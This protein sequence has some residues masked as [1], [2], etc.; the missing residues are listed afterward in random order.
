MKKKKLLLKLAALTACSVIAFTGCQVK[1]DNSGSSSANTES[2]TKKGTRKIV[3]A[4]GRTVEIPEKV[5]KV[6]VDSPT[7]FRLYSYINKS[8][9][10]VGVSDRDKNGAKDVPYGFAFPEKK[11]IKAFGS[12]YAINDFEGVVLENPDVIFSVSKKEIAEYDKIQAQTKVPVIALD[13]GKD[14]IFD[15]KMYNSL[16]IIGKVMGKEE[17]SKEVIDYMRGLKKDLEERAGKV[18]EVKTAYAGGLVWN[19]P[20]GIE[21]TR[22]NYAL[23]NI[24]KVK[25]VVTGL[26][27]NG[28]VDIDKEKILEWNP[29]YIILDVESMPLIQDDYNKNK[30]FY[31]SIRAFKEGKVFGQLPFAKYN[32]N[33]DTAML[34]AYF[35]G[36]TI[37]P[38]NFKDIDLE[39]KGD[40]IY[41]KLL[42]KKLYSRVV[43]RF[44][45]GLQPITLED[46]DNNMF[47]KKN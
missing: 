13:Q 11:D 32:V 9:N 12:G 46:L 6:I 41:E 23:F 28:H 40:E 27:K 7:V 10:I 15:E 38:E 18:K 37:Y 36:K 45:K 21:G 2:G 24:N 22:E 8:N 14:F 35:I 33:I 31:K 30:D 47:I 5:S 1:Q 17:R 4:V 3:D 43:G 42:G 44:P 39:K 16:E 34:D 19:G 26:N 20:H 25:N 29:E